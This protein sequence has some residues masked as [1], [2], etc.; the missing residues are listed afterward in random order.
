[1]LLRNGDS[2]HAGPSAY[3]W[4]LA[5]ASREE[6][7]D[8]HLSHYPGFPICSCPPPQVLERRGLFTGAACLVTAHNT[9]PGSAGFVP[10]AVVER[11][12]SICHKGNQ[13]DE[14]GTRESNRFS[15]DDMSHHAILRDRGPGVKRA[16]KKKAP[17]I[18]KTP[19]ASKRR[20]LEI[21]L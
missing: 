9:E 16:P 2:V 11:A 17:G 6:R 15:G 12:G 19:G 7:V 1:M 13:Q 10:C 8:N 20:Y 3:G 14:K 21:Q 18:K 4:P 5:E